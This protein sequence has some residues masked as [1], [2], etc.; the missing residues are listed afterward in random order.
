M[1]KANEV[2]ERLQKAQFERMNNIYL[3]CEEKGLRS[4]FADNFYY[5]I[6]E[7]P[8]KHTK[9]VLQHST[10]EGIFQLKTFLEIMLEVMPEHEKAKE[11]KESIKLLK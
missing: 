3:K 7:S 11:W 10:A 6:T 4:G 9:N 8:L 1:N 5:R 2:R